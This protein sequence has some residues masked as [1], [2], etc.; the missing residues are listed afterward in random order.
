MK[1]LTLIILMSL[2]SFSIVS[3]DLGVKVGVSGQIGE[4]SSTGSETNSGTGLTEKVSDKG[5]LATGS[6][7]IEKDLKFIPLPFVN[8]F[9]FG[10]DNILHDLNLGSSSNTR[11]N[12]VSS[13]DDGKS[14]GENRLQAK[15]TGMETIYAT[16]N[17]TDWL[18]VKA[19][20]IDVDI[21]TKFKSVGNQSIYPT[22]HAL[23]GSM[24]VAGI[25]LAKENGFFLRAEINEIDIG[26]KS[27]KNTGTD[28]AGVASLFSVKL[29]GTTGT[30]SRI[31]IGKSF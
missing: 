28:A 4:M 13:P 2:F 12:N 16:F 5:I 7:F 18:Y 15:L 9:S 1:K 10:Y 3:A 27:V 17:I 11:T 21:K 25:H 19:G 20:E 26:G 23:S 22:T 14:Y 6:F 24:Y 8:R 29:D 30:T 31:S